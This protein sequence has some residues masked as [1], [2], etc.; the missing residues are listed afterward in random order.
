MAKL[1]QAQQLARIRERPVQPGDWRAA[2]TK[3][4][5]CTRLEV[6]I[7]RRQSRRRK[8]DDFAYPF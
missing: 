5:A 7:S 8:P 2:R 4:R 1:T 3:A 6:A